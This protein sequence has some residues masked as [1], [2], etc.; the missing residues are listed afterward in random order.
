MISFVKKINESPGAIYGKG[1]PM[2][3]ITCAE[4]QLELIF[5]KEYK[6]YLLTFSVMAIDGR[7]F[8]GLSKSKRVNVVSVTLHQRELNP[9]LPC[10]WYVVEEANIDGIVIWQNSDGAIYQTQP[11][12]AAIKIADS[13]EK[14][15]FG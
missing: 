3:S 2:E 9:D 1:S 11:G 8:T 10:D 4:N 6:E 13:F 5:A 15:V 14:Y 12:L 7:E